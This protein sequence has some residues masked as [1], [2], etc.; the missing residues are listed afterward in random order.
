MSDTFEILKGTRSVKIGGEVIEIRELSWMELRAF[1]E[2]LAG[3][4]DQIA[5]ALG[6]GDG[7]ITLQAST[8][9]TMIRNSQVLSETLLKNTTGKDQEWINKLSCGEFMGLI[10]QALDLN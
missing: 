7:K 8:A 6:G 9:I 4:L 3:E 5:K 1:T 2:Q 10:D